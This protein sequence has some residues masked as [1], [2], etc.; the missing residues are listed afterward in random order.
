MLNKLFD[1]DENPRAL[2]ARV[3]I[4]SDHFAIPLFLKAACG[5]AAAIVLAD[6]GIPVAP[7]GLGREPLAQFANTAD[8]AIEVFDRHPG[9]PVGYDASS[10]PFSILLGTCCRGTKAVLRNAP[11]NSAPAGLADNLRM[12]GIEIDPLKGEGLLMIV[13]DEAG[14]GFFVRGRS[15][16]VKVLYAAPLWRD[17]EGTGVIRP[18]GI[19]AAPMSL[20]HAMAHDKEMRDHVRDLLKAD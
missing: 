11:R 4:F 2:E 5:T 20:V 8:S 19:V 6:A 13:P 12:R 14:V 15:A 17:D 10:L 9:V 1:C 18:T 3:T 7:I 16:D